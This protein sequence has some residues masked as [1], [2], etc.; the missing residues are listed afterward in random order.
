MSTTLELVTEA[1]DLVDGSAAAADERLQRTWR[2]RL[3]TSASLIWN[4]RFWQFK[5][6]EEVIATDPILTLQTPPA[7]FGSFEALGAGVY[8]TDS[9]KG[10]LDALTAGEMAA[11]KHS[12]SPQT[13][14]PK[15]YC[16]KYES[17]SPRIE[18]FPNP[19]TAIFLSVVYL[20]RAPRLQVSGVDIGTD[21][22]YFIPDQWHDLVRWGGEWLNAMETANSTSSAKQEIWKA[23]LDEMRAR[24]ACIVN[25]LAPWRPG[26][27]RR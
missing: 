23:G 18:L 19:P 15:A 17:G 25:N 3:Q 20:R 6:L 16:L 1:I 2:S 12:A 9:P 4:D 27:R 22:L 5:A 11:L 24:E 13:G 7:D 26:R 8:L 10:P 14:D 21:E